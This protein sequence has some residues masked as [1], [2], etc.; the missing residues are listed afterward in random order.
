M[1]KIPIHFDRNVDVRVRTCRFLLWLTHNLTSSFLL[2]SFEIDVWQS[3]KSKANQKLIPTRRE[4]MRQRTEQLKNCN[5]SKKKQNNELFRFIVS[6]V[7]CLFFEILFK[8]I[9]AD[10][11]AVCFSPFYFILFLFELANDNDHSSTDRSTMKND[12]KQ[13]NIWN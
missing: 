3:T 13:K 7:C 1:P 10:A 11:E 12:T 4:M 9:V 6:S 2:N 8:Q 5:N